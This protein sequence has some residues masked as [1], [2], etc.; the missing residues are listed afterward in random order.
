MRKIAL[1]IVCMAA[2]YLMAAAQ[3]I[4]TPSMGSDYK[5]AIGLKYWPGA[6]T[7]KTFVAPNKS[8]EGLLY[9][10]QYGVR[11]TG[12]YEFNGDVEGIQGLKWYAG[13]GAHIGGW[14]KKWRDKYPTRENGV[15]IGID[16]VLGVDYKINGLPI[17]VSLDWQPS[18]T[19]VGYNYFEGAWGG[20]AIRY[21]F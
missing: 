5:T 14:N 2:T 9:V 8:V 3:D 17:N 4:K 16:G 13:P 11:A 7:A 6:L 20:L 15:S 18:F 12:L 19:L 10:F 1:T 21:A